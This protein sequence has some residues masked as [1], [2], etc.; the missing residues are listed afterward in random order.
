[1]DQYAPVSETSIGYDVFAP[2]WGILELAAVTSS[3]ME[4]L[5]HVSLAGFVADNRD[6][7]DEL[8]E[9]VRRVGNFSDETL[10]IFEE[11]GGWNVERQVTA[12]YLMMYSGCIE[13]YPPDTGDPEVLRHMVQT[14]SDLQL[15]LFMHA[16]V[17][18]A[19]VRGPG[20]EPASA[21]IASAVRNGSSLLGI[22]DARA[23][24]DVFRMWRVKFLPD[25]LRP[26]APVREGFKDT[27]REYERAL[28][29]LVDPGHGG[30]SVAR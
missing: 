17:S 5:Q 4:S 23:S 27:V 16:L 15:T 20:V 24:A 2:L 11:Q 8:L 14:G 6:E 29:G 26:D 18:A 9:A 19:A 7:L 28:E 1:M 21:L 3:G 22:R 10:R 12:E 13:R 30:E 25:L